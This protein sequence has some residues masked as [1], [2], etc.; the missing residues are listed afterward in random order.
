MPLLFDGSWLQGASKREQTEVD[1]MSLAKFDPTTSPAISTIVRSAVILATLAFFVSALANAFLG[2]RDIA[3]VLA[4]A[5]PLGISAW[6]F[7]RAGHNEA[8]LALLCCV[9]VAV[10]TLIL[11]LSPL[12]VHDVAITAYAGVLSFSAML[13]SRRAFAGMAAITLFAATAAFVYDLGGH[14]KSLISTFSGWA[15]YFGFLLISGG[16]AFLGRMVAEK[17]F[18]TLGDAHAAAGTDGVTGLVNRHGFLAAAAQRLRSAQS[19]SEGGVLV[20][21]DLDGFKRM[22]LVVG[23]QA[24]DGVL[25]EC[26]ARLQKEFGGDLVGRIGDD[27][28]A[29]MRVGM[30]ES[31]AAQ[32]ALVVHKNLEFEYQGV[33]VRN[34][35][36]YARFPRDATGIESLLMTAESGVSHAK[37]RASERV[38]GP[39]D[40]I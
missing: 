40:R 19:R 37:D 9:L 34:A 2:S 31:H 8:A 10:I 26:A 5:A 38:A 21:V 29:V 23:H 22:N 6:G 13:F 16:F 18:G 1:P 25:R 20:L 28:F 7:V 15:Q 27:E 30:H 32:F 33:S 4:L 17:L 35:A 12:G 14:S 3:V 11:M 24:A 39:A 36:G